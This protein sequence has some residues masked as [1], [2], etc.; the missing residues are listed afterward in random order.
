MK[1]WLLILILLILLIFDN[2]LMPFLAIKGAYPSLLFTFAIAYSM[3]TKKGDAV[4]I[5][6]ATGMLQD[7]FFPNAFGIN[8]LVNMLL[9]F[10][11]SYIGE[12]IYKKKKL[13][14]V[15]STAFIYMAKV[16]AI[17][18]IFKVANLEIN[19]LVGIYSSLYSLVIMFLGYNFVLKLYGDDYKER[20]WRLR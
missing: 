20:S 5:G 17:F 8:S 9:C 10:A 15:I 2:S 4:F 3:V 13:I 11:A 12:N 19:L 1:R 7:I 6:V 14:P 16:L 18:L